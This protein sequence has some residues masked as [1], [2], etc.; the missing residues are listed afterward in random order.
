MRATYDA[1]MLRVWRSTL[2]GRRQW[3]GQLEHLPEGG[4]WKF[5]CPE[6][7]LAHFSNLFDAGTA[8]A[9]PRA[10]DA[11][12]LASQES[13]AATGDGQSD[14]GHARLEATQRRDVA[15]R[16]ESVGT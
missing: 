16:K 14:R 2:D 7:L 6:D 10:E 8:P 12:A 15:G 5:R 1:Y 4:V 9:Q 11:A 3:A 13:R